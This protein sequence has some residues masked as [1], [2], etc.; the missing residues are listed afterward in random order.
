MEEDGGETQR[1]AAI[2]AT[3]S[4]PLPCSRPHRGSRR[5][6]GGVDFESP[7]VHERVVGR[8]ESIHR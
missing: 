2:S 6:Q 3:G 5:V 4:L 7:P 8:A 1:H